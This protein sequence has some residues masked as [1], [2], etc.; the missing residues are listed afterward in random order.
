M[1]KEQ[2][3][4]IYKIHSIGKVGD[5]IVNIEKELEDSYLVGTSNLQIAEKLGLERCDKYYHQGKVFKKD[6]IVS[7]ERTQIK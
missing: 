3:K 6:I 1:N 2:I 7:E 4:E 5:L